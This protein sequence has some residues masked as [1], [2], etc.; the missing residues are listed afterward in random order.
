M[1]NYV[2]DER[3]LNNIN[4]ALANAAIVAGM[5][6]FVKIIYDFITN[7]AKFETTGWFAILLLVM[8]IVIYVSLYRSKST[9]L[10]TTLLGRPLDTELSIHAKRTR[11]YKSYIPESLVGAAGLLVGSYINSEYNG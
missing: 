2:K 6:L 11:L 1:N 5:L 3:V 7:T 9:Q 8:G 10:P 4:K